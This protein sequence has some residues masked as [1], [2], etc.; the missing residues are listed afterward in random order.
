MTYLVLAELHVG[1][2]VAGSRKQTHTHT[3]ALV[4][5]SPRRSF[6]PP[7][8][9]CKLRRHSRLQDDPQLHYLLLPRLNVYC[10]SD[11]PVAAIHSWAR[12]AR[13]KPPR[14]P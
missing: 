6:S 7:S 14:V 4:A 10:L 13:G 5:G 1:G 12:A 8:Q 9:H 11:L 3:K 2:W